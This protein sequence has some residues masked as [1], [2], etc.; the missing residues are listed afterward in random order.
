MRTE[1]MSLAS[2]AI[3]KQDYPHTRR[4]SVC[5]FCLKQ[6]NHGLL[7][8]WP[9]FREQGLRYG[10]NERQRDLLDCHEFG[11]ANPE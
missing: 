5:P 8:C 9:C 11:L 7:T 6:K 2:L 4:G 3:D 1:L 10:E